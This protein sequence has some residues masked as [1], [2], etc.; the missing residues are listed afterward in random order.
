MA[1]M[2]VAASLLSVIPALEFFSRSDEGS[3]RRFTIP[4]LMIWSFG[5]CLFG[6]VWS[7]SFRTYFIRRL[8]LR[9]PGGYATGVLVGLLHGD[10]ETANNA[11]FHTRN[12][13]E[14][15]ITDETFEPSELEETNSQDGLKWPSS[16]SLMMKAFCGTAVW[17]SFSAGAR[18]HPG[19][20][21][22]ILGCHFVLYS[23]A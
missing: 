20:L 6:I 3:N 12:E 18:R 21:S 13:D 9:F 7:S 8:R 4:E 16:I 15:S 23:W 14:L 2:P 5:V 22:S 11:R 1:G 10:T 17:V 19:I